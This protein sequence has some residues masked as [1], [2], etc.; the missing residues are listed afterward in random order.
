[1]DKLDYACKYDI[2]LYCRLRT[3]TM[4]ALIDNDAKFI[5]T[6]VSTLTSHYPD[7]MIEYLDGGVLTSWTTE[8]NICNIHAKH[9]YQLYDSEFVQRHRDMMIATMFKE[10]CWKDIIYMMQTYGITVS[11]ENRL[12]IFKNYKQQITGE[13]LETLKRGLTDD[14]KT[15]FNASWRVYNDDA[16]AAAWSAYMREWHDILD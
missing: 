14:E 11:F 6:N 16:K 15:Q 12:V 2:L 9:I 4:R 5:F 13:E 3:G 7:L 8:E 10:Q 1:M